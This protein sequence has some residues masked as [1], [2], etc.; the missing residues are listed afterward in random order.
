[1]ETPS[2]GAAVP[3]DAPRPDLGD[4]EAAPLAGRVLD[5]PRSAFVLA[6]WRDPGG[7]PE[8]PRL[9]APPHVHH[10]DDEAWYVLEGALRF[11]LGER[12]LDVP[13]GS[14]VIAPRGIP[15]T[16][17]NFTQDPARYLLVMTPRIRR[18]IDDLHSGEHE[19]VVA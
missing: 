1:P 4:S 3:Q 13:A 11:R 12:E 14:G 7:P 18:L 15:H 17:G 2:R 5:V 6:E 8:P 9:I 10:G 19:D 16:F